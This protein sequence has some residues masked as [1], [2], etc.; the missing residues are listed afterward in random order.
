MEAEAH[1][2]EVL[3]ARLA[4][5]GVEPALGVVDACVFAEEGVVAVDDPGVDAEDCLVYLLGRA[6]LGLYQAGR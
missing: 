2:D 6:W 1:R 4:V 3:L 5:F